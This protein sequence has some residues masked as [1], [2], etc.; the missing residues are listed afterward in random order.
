MDA[1]IQQALE[2]LRTPPS[3]RASPPRAV[4]RG[5]AAPLAH[6]IDGQLP[7]QPLLEQLLPLLCTMF[8]GAAAVVWMK[9]HGS[10]SAI[11]GVRYQMDRLLSD[12]AEQKQHQRLVQLA[13]R[14]DQPLLV[15]CAVLPDNAV[16]QDV[17]EIAKTFDGKPSRAETLGEFRYDNPTG[18]PLLFAPVIHHGETLALLEIALAPAAADLTVA[19]RQLYVRASGLVARRLAGGLSDRIHPAPPSVDR[20]TEQLE[21]LGGEVRDLQQQI[22]QRIDQRLQQFE[23]WAFASLADKQVFAKRVQRL[24]EGHGLRVACSECGHAAILRA[25]AIG[26][27][28]HGAFVFDHYLDSGRTFHGGSTTVPLIRV[29]SKPARRPAKAGPAGAGPSGV[30]S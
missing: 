1:D 21:S 11:V 19:E 16:K 29:V 8:S 28:K 26:N 27:A 17:A 22:R 15:E 7:L 4:Q 9:A 6:L 2:L 30:G 13:W 5:Q 25:V 10:H 23:G 14:Q 24:L 3:Q 20:A 12:V 18:Y